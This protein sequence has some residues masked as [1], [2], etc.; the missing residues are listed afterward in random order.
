[1]TKEVYKAVKKS[2][3]LKIAHLVLM[4]AMACG[5]VGA[6]VNF[7]VGYHNA[8][9]NTERLSNLMNVFLMAFILAMLVFGAM[10]LMKGYAKQAA[11]D[12][13]AF[14]ILHIIVC[15]LTIYI[16]LSFYKVNAL[17]IAISVANACKAVLLLIL[18]FGKDLG[19][20]RTWILFYILLALDIVKLVFAIINMANIGFDFSFMGYVT[21]LIADGTI[22]LAI[23]GKYEDKSARGRN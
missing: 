16:D 22:G 19:R 11:N 4:I 8:S 7:I 1:M 13:K 2:S 18:A 12:Y 10:Y 14:M 6:A 9:A 15:A 5:T 23:R 21:A 3:P 17:M 20:S